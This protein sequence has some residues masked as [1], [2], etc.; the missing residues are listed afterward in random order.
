[1]TSVSK[2]IDVGALAGRMLIES[3]AEMWRVEDTIKHIINHNPE[4]E[5][6]AFTSLTGVLVNLQDDSS[7]TR[8]VQVAKRG[9]NMNKIHIINHL[10]RQYSEN[11]IDIDELKQR[12]LEL[13]KSKSLYPLWLQTLGAGLESAFLM[14]T[15][16]QK[17]D[18][19]DLP[20]TF[21]AGAL[22]YIVTWYVGEHVKIRFMSEFLGALTV[23]ISVV[24]GVRLNLGISISNII[25]G[26]IM[27]LVPGV[28]M[29]TA[30]R[31]IFEGNLLSG[32]ERMIESL[33][34]ISAIA[35]GIGAV[36]RYA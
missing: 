4:I 20:L 33:I 28:P 30:L 16:T 6:E 12:L 21:V 15:F 26:A 34:V 27:P 9:I 14:I 36:L 32:I 22:G 7:A 25:I 29:T 10:S 2:T 18:W 35:F 24:I 1:M 23:G 11:V 13:S 8:F 17:Y 31:D 5:A 19:F 3:G